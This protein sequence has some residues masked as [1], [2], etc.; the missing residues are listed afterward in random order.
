MLHHA[1]DLMRY[2]AVVE[3]KNLPIA[4][5]FFNPSLSAVSHFVVGKSNMP[6]AAHAAVSCRHSG[7]PDPQSRAIGLAVTEDVISDAPSVGGP[8][9]RNSFIDEDLSAGDKIELVNERASKWL[10]APVSNNTSET[11]GH[12]EDFLIDWPRGRISHAVV[13]FGEAL[14]FDQAIV[15][16]SEYEVPCFHEPTLRLS[17]DPSHLV[18]AESSEV[19]ERV[20]RHWIDSLRDSICA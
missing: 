6:W 7:V 11:V 12:V 1:T 17:T 13:K 20:D 19:L 3:G 10:L 9:E 15:P 14:P 8:L 5:L 18:D 4:D 16:H 2:K